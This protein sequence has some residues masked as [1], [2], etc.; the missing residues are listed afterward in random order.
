V[1]LKVPVTARY[2]RLTNYYVPDGK[3]AVSGLRVF[4]KGNGKLAQ[5]VTTFQAI[6]DTADARNVTL[7]WPKSDSATGYNIRYGT[8]PGKLYHNYQVFDTNTLTIH[9][10]NRLQ[11]YYFAIDA[12]NENGI[13][14]GT[15][16]KGDGN[17]EVAI[18]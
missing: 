16:V 1:E 5:P 6:R 2:I 3:F 11:Q 15:V 8:K 14:K 7:T 4:G 13:T 18:K 17:R 12:F 10:L 9:S